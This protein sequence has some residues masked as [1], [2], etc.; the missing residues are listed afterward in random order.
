M[1]VSR[2]AL[3]SRY[4]LRDFKRLTI[5]HEV[6]CLHN[7]IT[8]SESSGTVHADIIAR[9]RQI[10]TMARCTRYSNRCFRSPIHVVM[11]TFDTNRV[12]NRGFPVVSKFGFETEHL[13]QRA[14][15]QM[16]IATWSPYARCSSVRLLLAEPSADWRFRGEWGLRK[17]VFLWRVTGGR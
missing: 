2:S 13:V 10:S 1:L 5:K 11:P 12:Q 9:L 17:N 8:L 3:H 16:S 14:I 4:P 15:V 6:V 7:V